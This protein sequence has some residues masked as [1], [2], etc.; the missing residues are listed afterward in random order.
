M[1]CIQLRILLQHY[2]DQR[3]HFILSLVGRPVVV[4]ESLDT[5]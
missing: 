5:R 4:S 3:V 1:V 2:H